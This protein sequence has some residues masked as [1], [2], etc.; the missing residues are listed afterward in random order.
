MKPLATRTHPVSVRAGYTLWASSYDQEL[1]PLIMTEAPRVE[2]LLASLPAPAKML[3][4]AAGTGR[5]ARY[6]ARQGVAVTAI[7]PSPEMLAAGRARAQAEGLAVRFE[8][9]AIEDG[10]PFGAGSFDLVI[11]ALALC[12]VPDLRA[13]VAECARVLRPGG[14]LIITDFHPQ[15]V[16]NGWNTSVFRGEDVYVLST[17]QHAAEGYIEAVEAAGCRVIHREEV[18]VREQPI[19]SVL[20]QEDIEGFMATYGDWPFCLILAARKEG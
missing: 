19:E 6:L 16:A 12:H 4:V 5:W 7:D 2:R 17:V 11:C 20:H 10:L 18:L 14:H 1:N 15:A 13:A 8:E 9:G 3:D